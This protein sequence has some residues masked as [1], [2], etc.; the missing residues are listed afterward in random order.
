[1]RVLFVTTTYP[2]QPG[3]SVPSFVADLASALVRD[4]GVSVRVVAPH[5]PSARKRE[6]VNGVEIERFQYA[7]DPSAQCVAYGGGIP[8]NLRNFPR[9]KWQLPGFFAAMAAAVWRNVGWADLIHAHWVEPAFLAMAANWA[10][11][12]VVV[13]V[14]S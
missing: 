12:P 13:S 14:H 9:A 5:H 4:H 6:V 2:L 10:R 7:A 3:D 11:R 1:M 8:D